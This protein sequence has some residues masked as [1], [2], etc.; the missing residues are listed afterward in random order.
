MPN[1]L[2]LEWTDNTELYWIKFAPEPNH[3]DRITKLSAVS[4][5]QIVYNITIEAQRNV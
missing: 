3:L 4:K 5:N 2:N 1:C